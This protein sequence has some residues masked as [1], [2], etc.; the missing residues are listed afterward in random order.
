MWFRRFITWFRA[1]FSAPADVTSAP[2]ARETPYD[3]ALSPIEPEFTRRQL[4][5]PRDPLKT[6]GLGPAHDA[7]TLEPTSYESPTTIP[8][9]RLTSQMS[10][11]DE[12]PTQPILPPLPTLNETPVPAPTPTTIPAPGR[13]PAREPRQSA[14]SEPLP[15]SLQRLSDLPDSADIFE[16]MD[17]LDDGTRR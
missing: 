6:F 17:D 12:Q 4:F 10:R 14:P 2:I 15:A 7:F 13:E 1:R 11:L 3:G 9:R 5:Y 16:L 8:L